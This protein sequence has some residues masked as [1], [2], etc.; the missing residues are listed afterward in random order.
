MRA[1]IGLTLL[2]LLGGALAPPL[3]AADHDHPFVLIAHPDVPRGT[4]D[5]KTVRRIFLGKKTRWEGGLP[6]VPVMLREGDLHEAFV[7]E[8]LDRTVSKF[9]VYW[10]QAVFTGRGIPPRSFETEEELLA[11]VASTPG[12]MGYV[13]EVAPLSGVKIVTCE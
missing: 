2:L 6:V 10:K 7:E 9:E 11:F 4:C 3:H 5:E 8:M 13:S 12:A 1:L